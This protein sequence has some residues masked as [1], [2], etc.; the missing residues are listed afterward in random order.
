MEL[1]KYHITAVQHVT[2]KAVFVGDLSIAEQILV[3]KVVYSKYAKARILKCD[4]S[5]ALAV[6][7]V[8]DI[9]DYKRI[10]GDNQMNH[11]VQDEPCLAV[12]E[13][14]CIGQ[15]ILLIA[16]KTYDAAVEAERL[17]SIEYEIQEPILTIED[18][19]AK[20]SRMSSPRKIENG[21]PDK[22]MQEAD[23]VFEG[24]IHTG[25]QEHWYLET[26][27]CVCVPLE[28]GGMKV[29]SSTQNPTET[30]LVVAEV[31]GLDANQV[32]CEV[33]R[34]GG[35]FGGKETQANHS[36]AWAALLANATGK[37]VKIVLSRDDDQK[38]TGKRHRF[39]SKF[40][41]GFNNDGT[42]QS[43]IIDLNADGGCAMDLTMA[44]IERAMFH[45][46]NS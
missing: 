40:K 12:N 11:L 7:G 39:Y 41:I 15:P 28:D 30:Q 20:N 42:I 31:L 9:L 23:H 2:G 17:I 5:K 10:P 37:A 25:G 29:Y 14:V 1:E 16:A 19:I 33:N 44:I 36:A 45:A 3:G 8:V 32:E 6:E 43:Y 18:A 22:A 13:V 21:D 35:A 27:S 34:M 46:E 4:F 24:D 26:Q 38:I